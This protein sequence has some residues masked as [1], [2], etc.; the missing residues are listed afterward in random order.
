M[1]TTN[2][3]STTSSYANSYI[4]TKYFY[5]DS[6]GQIEICGSISNTTVECVTVN[7]TARPVEGGIISPS[8]NTTHQSSYVYI[9]YYAVNYS[10][11]YITVNG[12]YYRNLGSHFGYYDNYSQSWTNYNNSNSTNYVNLGY[13]QSIICLDLIG[14]DS[15]EINDCIS[16]ERAVPY[17]HVEITYPTNNLSLIGQSLNLSYII[18]NSSSHHYTV[19]GVSTMP[20]GNSSSNYIQLFVGYGNPTVCVVSSDLAGTQFSDCVIVNMIDPNA[21]SDSDGVPDHSDLCPN[22]MPN[23]MANQDGCALYQLDTDNDGVMDDADIC[24]NTQQFANVDSNGCAAYQRDSDGDGI[25]D[26]LD[27]CPSTPVNS[28]VD[29][30]GCAISQIDTDNDG[31]MDD[32]DMCPNTIVGSQ[33][34]ANGCAPSQL[35]S[36]SDGVVDSFDQCPN[37]PIGTVVSPSGCV[38]TNSGNNSGN[39]SGSSSGDSEGMPGFEAAYLVMSVIIAGFVLSRKKER[40]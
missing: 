24:P 16:V 9:S 7:R 20:Q 25:K 14:E 10:N 17:H 32:L 1:N 35:D 36:D 28:V 8:N 4:R 12:N 6:F 2:D 3:T 21:D 34:N 38:Y 40:I 39:N 31:V 37:T 30:Y 27:S 26:N 33:V 11:G 5:P 19:N 15:T 18:Q 23:I 13:G 22:T 29:S